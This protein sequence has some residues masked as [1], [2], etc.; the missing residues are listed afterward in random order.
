MLMAVDF[1]QA[2]IRNLILL[3]IIARLYDRN[4]VNFI[5]LEELNRACK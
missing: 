2:A 5:N 3:E 1:E 4:K